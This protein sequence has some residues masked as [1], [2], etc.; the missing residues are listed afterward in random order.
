M[1]RSR[2]HVVVVG[3]GL[4]GLMTA[5]ELAPLPVLLVTRAPLGR[6]LATA[7]AQGGVAAAVGP[8]DAPARHAADTHAAGDGIC[9]PHVV[10]LVTGDAPASIERLE[11]YGVRFDRDADGAWSLG[12]EGGHGRRC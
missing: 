9:D 8:D 4:G 3:A 2:H 1:N 7:W 11:R 12:R 10:S 5:L 6:D